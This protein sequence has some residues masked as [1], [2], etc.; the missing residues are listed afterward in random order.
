MFYIFFLIT[1]FVYT[2]T[3]NYI[4]HI[5]PLDVEQSLD[6]VDINSQAGQDCIPNIFLKHCKQSLSVTLALIFNRSLNQ[7]VFLPKWRESFI[8]PIHKKGQ[9][10]LIENL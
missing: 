3:K 1:T 5:T 7:G 9:K 10:N 2:K 8:T 6:G 4:L